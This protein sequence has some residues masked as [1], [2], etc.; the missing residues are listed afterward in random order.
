MTK[1]LLLP[2]YARLSRHLIGFRYTG[3]GCHWTSSIT[4]A[5]TTQL[6]DFV[7]WRARN[8][9]CESLCTGLT[10]EQ[11]HIWV[12]CR[13]TQPLT[14]RI[15]YKAL[16]YEMYVYW[17]IYINEGIWYEDMWM[18]MFYTCSF[19][20][21][22]LIL[23]LLSLNFF[24]CPWLFLVLLN[25]FKASI[26]IVLHSDLTVALVLKNCGKLHVLYVWNCHLFQ[27]PLTIISLLFK[28]EVTVWLT[29]PSQQGVWAVWLKYLQECTTQTVFW[30]SAIL[31]WE[32]CAVHLCKYLSDH[33]YIYIRFHNVY[34][35]TY[36]N[37]LWDAL[38]S[39]LNIQDRFIF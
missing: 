7:W 33:I 37:L 39:L 1:N 22:N 10:T 14:P 24:Y 34:F 16:E 13:K 17:Y 27:W 26:N 31:R 5:M 25:S 20:F 32:F 15:L 8:R 6:T 19:Q 11:W 3:S 23:V 36:I 35:H 38:Q 28:C 30:M 29:L 2:K 4:W 21:Q 9:M 18:L 12:M